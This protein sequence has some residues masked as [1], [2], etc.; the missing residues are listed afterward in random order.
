MA[1]V[2]GRTRRATIA[3][4]RAASRWLLPRN[5]RLNEN[6]RVT[7]VYVVNTSQSTGTVSGHG[8][9]GGGSGGTGGGGILH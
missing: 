3:P 1:R 6:T 4:E 5:K 2:R 9:K 8:V 7:L